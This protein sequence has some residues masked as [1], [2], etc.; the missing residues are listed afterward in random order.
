MP[1]HLE[2]SRADDAQFG[3]LEED[4]DLLESEP[5]LVAAGEEAF[6]VTTPDGEGIVIIGTLQEIREFA[7]LM[8]RGLDLEIEKGKAL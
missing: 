8:V 5:D 4:H 7:R 2:V 6:Y 1:A 3:F